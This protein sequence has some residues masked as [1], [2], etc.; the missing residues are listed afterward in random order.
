MSHDAATAIRLIFATAG[1]PGMV[2]G[3]M[4][5]E[6]HD[7]DAPQP[8]QLRLVGSD[9]HDGAVWVVPHER[10]KRDDRKYEGE[11]PFIVPLNALAVRLIGGAHCGR[12]GRVLGTP[13][14]TGTSKM[15]PNK[16]A[17]C[18][19]SL[20]AALKME[21]WTPHDARRT[22]ATM[23]G[24]IEV[25]GRAKFADHEIGWL[26]A[27]KEGRS[28]VSCTTEIYN[29]NDHFDEKRFMATM[30]GAELER[31]I[32]D[33]RIGLDRARYKRAA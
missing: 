6:L 25:P 16:L 9:H 19:R 11:E 14:L 24:A 27:H 21:R 23:L 10:M 33:E 26:L 28:S 4:T 20:V 8:T 13:T 15:K 30:L 31:C 7:L 12:D 2:C 29:R 32:R 3:M 17:G 1:R 5:R 22:A 18:V